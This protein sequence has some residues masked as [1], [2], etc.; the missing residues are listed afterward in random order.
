MCFHTDIHTG[1]RPIQEK[2]YKFHAGNSQVE[3][4]YVG[5]NKLYL[6]EH[7]TGSSDVIHPGGMSEGG[8]NDLSGVRERL[9]AHVGL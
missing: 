4:L 8:V 1:S 7:N 9:V 6:L 2:S 5:N 3:N